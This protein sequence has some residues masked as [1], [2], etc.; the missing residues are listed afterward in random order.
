MTALLSAS[1]LVAG[2]ALDRPATPYELLRME[3]ALRAPV[4]APFEP[5]DA[6]RDRRA[7][8]EVCVRLEVYARDE[9]N[10]RTTPLW[11]FQDELDDARTWFHELADCP[12]LADGDWLPPEEVSAKV[13]QFHDAWEQYMA[14]VALWNPDWAGRI[15]VMVR[16]GRRIR[17][18]YSTAEWARM[19]YAAPSTRRSHLRTLRRMIGEE[20]WAERR[21]PPTAVWWAFTEVR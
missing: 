20:A 17:E 21:L 12:P 8:A 14:E 9:A 7:L 1:L 6:A 16:E 18:V 4:G 13:R 19:S 10:W 3:A 11:G 5:G 2:L 15:E